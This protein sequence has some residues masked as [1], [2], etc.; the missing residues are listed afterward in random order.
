MQID[1]LT[2]A[3]IGAIKWS[4]GQKRYLVHYIYLA[5]WSVWHKLHA[6]TTTHFYSPTF[7]VSVGG[8]HGLTRETR[9]KRAAKC[10]YSVKI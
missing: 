8:K 2:D 7:R 5:G 10:F 1:A 3:A 9:M 6:G 4:A